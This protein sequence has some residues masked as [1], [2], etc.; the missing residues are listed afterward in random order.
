MKKIVSHQSKGAPESLFQT[1]AD[2]KQFYTN[3]DKFPYQ[4][5]HGEVKLPV[6]TVAGAIGLCR[7]DI[8]QQHETI[9]YCTRQADL[10]DLID[11]KGVSIQLRYNDSRRTLVAQNVEG[12]NISNKEER[13]AV[14]ELMA[15][16]H[17]VFLPVC[18]KGIKIYSEL[19]ARALG[20]RE[21]VLPVVYTMNVPD[22]PK[23]ATEALDTAIAN[24]V[25]SELH[26]QY[27][28]V[29]FDEARPNES[30]A[31]DMVNSVFRDVLSPIMAAE[32]HAKIVITPTIENRIAERQEWTTAYEACPLVTTEPYKFLYM[33]EAVREAFFSD[34]PA[35][36]G[37]SDFSSAW[38][39][40]YLLSNGLHALTAWYSL[41]TGGR[42]IHELMLADNDEFNALFDTA[43][44]EIKAFL[45]SYHEGKLDTGVLETYIQESIK[46]RFKNYGLEDPVTRVGRNPHIKI[47][48][49]ERLCKPALYLF[50]HDKTPKA[51][52]TAVYLGAIYAHQHAEVT[53]FMGKNGWDPALFDDVMDVMLRGDY[54]PVRISTGSVSRPQMSE[55]VYSGNPQI[56][57]LRRELFHQCLE[58]SDFER[59][60]TESGHTN[61]AFMAAV[62]DKGVALHQTLL[63][64]RSDSR[65]NIPAMAKESSFKPVVNGASLPVFLL[66]RGCEEMALSASSN[67]VSTMSTDS[68]N[69]LK[70]M[71][72]SAS[73]SSNSDAS[74]VVLKARGKAGGQVLSANEIN[75]I[76]VRAPF[77]G[78]P[79]FTGFDRVTQEG[80]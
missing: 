55:L 8:F 15:R 31:H 63:S 64:K 18:A 39:T 76:K 7:A 54:S 34:N 16:A 73:F 62:Y 56:K 72:V 30:V 57:S 65:E 46:V 38:D 60:M 43:A 50:E 78:V 3:L 1:V 48:P 37:F 27:P 44:Q 33:D 41:Q 14:V 58:F 11:E 26:V 40:K 36:K 6:V 77:K 68:T 71:A 74:P 25:G 9:Y 61:Q 51:L 28:V 70:A 47:G 23:I 22:G 69:S 59:Y 75:A 45:L 79:I 42:Y 24:V 67:T 35:I 80:L 52:M 19:V 5:S 13:S 17:S 49:N 12:V 10:I 29:P 2:Y 20:K 53:S 66:E 4:A 21:T 32:R